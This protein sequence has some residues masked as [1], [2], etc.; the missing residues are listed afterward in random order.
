MKCEAEQ[1]QETKMDVLAWL[2]QKDF[3]ST[4]EEAD[5]SKEWLKC[6]NGLLTY[7]GDFGLVDTPALQAL[8][9]KPY[10]LALCLAKSNHVTK[11]FEELKDFCRNKSKDLFLRH[12]TC[13]LELCMKT[14]VDEGIIRLHAHI[15]LEAPFGK[16][17]RVKSQELL[18]FMGCKPNKSLSTVMTALGQKHCV[19][20]SVG[21]YYLMMPKI[22]SVLTWSTCQ[23]F[24]DYRVNLDHI[25][26]YVQ[27][28][29][30]T[31]EDAKIE[32]CK[33]FKDPER[34]IKNIEY[35]RKVLDDVTRAKTI[36][37]RREALAKS[38]SPSCR[39]PL[40]TSHGN[41]C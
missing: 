4:Y 24:I 1:K 23:P 6:Q 36:A 38:R 20:A 15:M 25:M 8:I 32:L 28:Q 35:S 13:S 19:N 3:K 39:R 21:H 40:V 30:I 34:H 18:A 7:Q 5:N 11:L 9:E 29:K 26:T 17:I 31:A 10:V 37:T 33:T 22:G 14:L 2:Y 12:V 16:H 27:N 41:A